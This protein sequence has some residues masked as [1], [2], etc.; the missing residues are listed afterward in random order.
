MADYGLTPEGFKQKRLADIIQSMNSRIAD[1]LGV[2]IST[3]A[4]SVFGQLIGVFSYEIA[5]L[6]EQAAQVY[7]A[8]YPHTAS[9]VSLDNSAALAGITPI[10]AEKT[11]VVCTCYGTNGTQI[12]YG[13]QISSATD[14]NI[15]F[16]CVDANAVISAQETCDVG[17]TLASVT[18]GETYSATVD[19]IIYS[20]TATSTDTIATVLTAIGSQITAIPASVENDVL[21]IT[22][23][24]QENTFSVAISNNM[25][26]ET[27]GSPV[28]FECTTDGAITPAIGDLTDIVTTYAGWDSV[29]NNVSA[30]T[31]RL[32]ESDTALRQRWNA[33]LYTRSVGM[34]DSIASALMA[35]NGVTSAYVYE[36]DSDTTDE[37][38]RPP[39]SI[40]AVV[41][42]GETDEIGLT[43][44]KKK[45]AGIDTFGS[46]SVSINDSQGF[47]HTINFNR[48]LIVPIY[49][50]ITVTEYPEEALPTN[51]QAMITEA[52]LNYGNSLTVGNDVI[53]QRFMGAIYQNVAGIGYIT[54]TASTNGST[55]SSNNISI[56]ARHVATFD[57]TRIQ[58]TIS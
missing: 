25:T 45:A 14:S 53:L 21:R 36:N 32:A 4:N 43:I 20:H 12:P 15:I 7:G 5:D 55:Y 44:W 13:A 47:P 56:D 33:S 52:V 10:A 51:A 48:P 40:E 42:G 9:G 38:G 50:N 54:V 26:F 28:T 39:H 58:V 46:Q 17:I 41:N 6:W 27:I 11:T 8:M 16:Q 49:L 30:N 31:G 23:S 18:E 35:L 1:Q 22:E 24:N 3:E 34:T 19:G 29:S 2:Q 57:A 37:D